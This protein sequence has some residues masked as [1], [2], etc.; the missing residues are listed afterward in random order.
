MSLPTIGIIGAGK[1][2][3]TLAQLALKAGY[4]VYIAGSGEPDKIAMTVEVL[5]PGAHAVT[6]RVAAQQADIVIL[7]MPLSKFRTLPR[8]E[9]AGK[10]VVDSTN[11]WWETD[12][13]REDFLPSDAASSAAIQEFLPDARVVKAL[14][15]MGYHDLYDEPRPH[16]A[17]GR[18]AI[19]MAGN[20][21]ADVET[22]SRLID[23]LG[24]DPLYIGDLAEGRR[25]EPGG[26]VFGA[27]VD[28]AELQKLLSL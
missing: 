4:T 12:G 10:L 23:S 26:P 5:T 8:E 18:K 11:Y 22:V 20:E 21:E 17:D 19:A 13:P 24:F 27:D 6:A 14:N 16:G 9:L 15:H 3:I 25:L 28:R 2:G 1:L 7:A